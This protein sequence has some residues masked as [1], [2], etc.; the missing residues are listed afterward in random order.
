MNYVQLVKEAPGLIEKGLV[1][2]RMYSR[3]GGAL[4]YSDKNSPAPFGV[5]QNAS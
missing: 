2:L 4:L 3:Y 1:G 5:L